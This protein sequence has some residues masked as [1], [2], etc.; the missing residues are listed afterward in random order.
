[1][2]I[3]FQTV[4]QYV[5]E[6]LVLVIISAIGILGAYVLKKVNKNKDL[7]N[8]AG[9]T[10]L[11]ISAA[12]ETVRRLQQT[13]VDGYKEAAPDGKLTPD[14]ILELK[15]KT[16]EIT[17]GTLAQPV[18]DLLLAAKVDVSG[19]ITNAAEAYINEMKTAPEA[20]EVE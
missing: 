15:E 1:M 12:Q 5:A 7:E 18:L 14:Q 20:T 11:V 10:E 16:L 2:D 19:L 17:M 8:I 6:I 4:V 3:I 13:L 9:A